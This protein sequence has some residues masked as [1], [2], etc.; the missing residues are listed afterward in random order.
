LS[1]ND[2]VNIITHAKNTRLDA[3]NQI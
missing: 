3:V 1:Q 2:Y